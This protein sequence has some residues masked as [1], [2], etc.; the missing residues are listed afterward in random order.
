MQARS[1]AAAG[2]AVLAGLATASSPAAHTPHP[3]P[4][5]VTVPAMEARAASSTSFGSR[6]RMAA[7]RSSVQ[8]MGR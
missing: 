6:S 7:Q 4:T 2:F 3:V 1:T 8:P 5:E